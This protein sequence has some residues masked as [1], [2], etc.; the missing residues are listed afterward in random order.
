MKTE[1]FD[2]ELV[3]TMFQQL[4]FMFYLQVMA[5]LSGSSPMLNRQVLVHIINNNNSNEDN[6]VTDN[7]IRTNRQPTMVLC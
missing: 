4:V 1:L 5:V 3:R 7:V 6:S 2:L